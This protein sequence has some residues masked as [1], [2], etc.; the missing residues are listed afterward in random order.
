MKFETPGMR[1]S[2]ATWYISTAPSSAYSCATALRSADGAECC[3]GTARAP[4]LSER[5]D[6]GVLR[7]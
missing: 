4:R 3:W 1:L 7:A 5:E 6:A 2:L